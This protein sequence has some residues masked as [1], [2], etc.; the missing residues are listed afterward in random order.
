MTECRKCF[1]NLK[2]LK[3]LFLN[4]ALFSFPHHYFCLNDTTL[5][6]ES[7]SQVCWPSATFLCLMLQ[8]S[9]GVVAYL[10]VCLLIPAGP[11]GVCLTTGETVLKDW[12]CGQ[13]L[14][15]GAAAISMEW[16]ETKRMLANRS[17][18]ISKT[19]YHQE[20]NMLQKQS[21]QHTAS[22]RP[23]HIWCRSTGCDWF[24]I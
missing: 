9:V 15:N 21:I 11:G 2:H 18:T 14:K 3:L 24:I 4:V 8:S 5:T 12:C 7:W 23:A 17:I 16:G 19:K 20:T 13:K 6:M 1:R 22:S 10:C